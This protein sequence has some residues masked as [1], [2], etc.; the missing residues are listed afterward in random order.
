MKCHIELT[1]G[2]GSP[3]GPAGPLSPGKPRGPASPRSPGAPRSPCTKDTLKLICACK[4][5]KAHV[6]VINLLSLWQQYDKFI[7]VAT[8]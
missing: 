1:A 3:D 4:I 7:L 6:N 8:I 5:L 2:P